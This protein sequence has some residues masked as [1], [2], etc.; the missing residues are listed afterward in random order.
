M[1]RFCSEQGIAY[2]AYMPLGGHGTGGLLPDDPRTNIA[3]SHGTSVQQV[4]LSWLRSQAS[5]IVPLVGSSRVATILDSV[6]SSGLHLLP[7]ELALLDDW[8]PVPADGT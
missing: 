1:A 4:A 3:R 2:L 7:E 5:G 8:Q 6:C